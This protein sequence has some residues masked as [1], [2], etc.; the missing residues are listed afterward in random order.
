MA[1]PFLVSAH[2]GQPAPKPA[3]LSH[4]LAL[5]RAGDRAVMPV[6]QRVYATSRGLLST[7]P[8][9]NAQPRPYAGDFIEQAA[10]RLQGCLA[11]CGVHVERTREGGISRFRGAN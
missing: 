5:Q 10:P 8:V 6:S 1:S 7:V 2:S 4:Y 3:Q 9:W 11:F